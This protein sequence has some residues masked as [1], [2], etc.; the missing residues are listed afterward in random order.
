M[1]VDPDGPGTDDDN[2]STAAT[3]GGHDIDGIM[4]AHL[5]DRNQFRER[6]RGRRTE[7]MM[8]GNDAR[9]S[10]Q[11]RDADET[12]AWQR[13][14]DPLLRHSAEHYL[15]R[16]PMTVTSLL[17]ELQPLHHGHRADLSRVRLQ[18]NDIERQRQTEIDAAFEIEIS[19]AYPID[20]LISMCSA[21]P[22]DRPWHIQ[23][24][25]LALYT[26]QERD[27]IAQRR[28]EHPEANP[29]MV[30]WDTLVRCANP[31]MIIL[32][33]ERSGLTAIA[34]VATGCLLY[35]SPS[36]RD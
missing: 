5:R 29:L 36:P 2:W 17:Q 34:Q 9:S 6:F 25:F 14:H 18:A 31:G 27:K 13:T 21:L 32:E 4:G 30:K 16:I 15:N 35:T 22:P 1:D 20:G 3:A 12:M 24:I 28:H 33:C 8:H 23:E 7:W 26:R 10:H 19:N 11:G